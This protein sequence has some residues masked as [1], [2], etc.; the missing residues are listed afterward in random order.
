[1]KCKVCQEEC[2]GNLIIRDPN[3]EEEMNCCS[4]CFNLWANQ[5]YEELTK[6]IKKR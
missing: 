3:I 1:M 5:K 4:T 6:R 2:I